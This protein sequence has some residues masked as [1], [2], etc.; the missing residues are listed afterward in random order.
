[1]Q[2]LRHNHAAFSSALAALKRQSNVSSDV[3]ATV[4]EII[5]AVRERG[6]AA[7]LELTAKFGSPALTAEQLRERR[8]PRVDVRPRN[9]VAAA[10][11]NVRDFA[12]RSLRKNWHAKNA[13]GAR[14]GERFDPF[15]RVGIYVPGGT[16]PL[17]STAIMTM[18]L[19]A[20]A[21]VPEI[22]VATPADATGKVN[23]ALLHALHFAGA[24]EI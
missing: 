15:Q 20:V 12:R 5:R 13:Q 17:V 8:R 16:A 7:L 4:R 2:I 3:E 9:A 18:T 14:V 21:G 6:D 19:A 22:V 11:V 24:T 10:H 23:D 1:M